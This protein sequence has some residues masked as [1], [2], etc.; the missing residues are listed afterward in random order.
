M[1]GYSQ[2]NAVYT[3]IN[4]KSRRILGPFVIFTGYRPTVQRGGEGV[5]E[6]ESVNS[7]FSET[8]VSREG[9]SSIYL[10]VRSHGPPSERRATSAPPVS[11]RIVRSP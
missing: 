7:A 2:Y 8:P 6:G 4:T 3:S 10:S 9:T 5:G 1:P 11:R